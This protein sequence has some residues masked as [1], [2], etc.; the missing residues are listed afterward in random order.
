MKRIIALSLAVFTLASCAQ[1][2]DGLEQDA[3]QPA[4]D[5]SVDS[6]S[7]PSQREVFKP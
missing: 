1:P 7:S 6:S 3:V 2:E 4:Q 5:R